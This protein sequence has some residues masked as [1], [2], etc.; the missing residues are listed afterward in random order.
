M[1]PDARPIPAKAAVHED[2]SAHPATRCILLFI[3]NANICA[4]IKR[5]LS[6]GSCV[7]IPSSKPSHARSLMEAGILFDAVL[8]DN[9]FPDTSIRDMARLI[10][11]QPRKPAIAAYAHEG[12]DLGEALAAMAHRRLSKCE[13]MEVLRQGLMR[14]LGDRA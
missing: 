12:D 8:L 9:E 10:S 5:E 14:L 4:I 11:E 3:Y 2:T 13:N 1:F 6:D 7:F